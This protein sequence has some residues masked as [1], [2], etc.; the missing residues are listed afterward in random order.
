MKN[1]TARQNFKTITVNLLGRAQLDHLL[2]LLASVPLGETNP[3]EVVIRERVR[4]RNNGQNALYWKRLAEIAEQAF[5]DGKSYD[6]D[7]WHH[8]CTRYIMPDTVLTKDGEVRSK[9]IDTPHSEVRVISTTQ[10][11]TGFF[12][13]YTEMVEA[14]GASLGVC[15]QANG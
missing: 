7:T 8:Y 6:A 9:W 5:V 14:Y 10:L 2:A 4:K 15:F 12:A 11:E 1:Q 3:L 13:Q